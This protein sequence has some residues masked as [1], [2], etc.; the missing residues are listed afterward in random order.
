MIKHFFWLFP[1]IFFSLGYIIP[2]YILR[3]SY[4]TIVP[5]VAQLLVHEAVAKLSNSG[6]LVRIIEERL[7][8]GKKSS[9]VLEQYPAPLQKVRKGQTVDLVV[10]PQSAL[11]KAPAYEGKLLSE[12]A[13]L[14]QNQ[15]FTTKII[16]Q[17]SSYPQDYVVAQY[18]ATGLEVENHTMF[19]YVSAGTS[20]W[21]I[22]PDLV[23]IPLE[24]ALERCRLQQIEPTIVHNESGF[25]S[26]TLVQ[27]QR[28][29]AGT[30]F[31]RRK[32]ITIQLHIR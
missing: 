21:W 13:H 10:T 5:S 31:D 1:F 22:M 20:F 4:T 6:L 11:T 27:G 18:P 7:S 30:V 25:N 19:L 17:E 9:I 24:Q 12:L 29:Q 16:Y 32:P 15:P 2:S 14:I 28:P 3:P 8:L 23:G 26:N